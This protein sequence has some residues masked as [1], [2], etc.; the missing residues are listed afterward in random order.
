MNDIIEIQDLK[1]PPI[2][3]GV[4]E[5]A[6]A[7]LR[8]QYKE[9]DASTDEGYEHCKDGCREMTALRTAVETR[10]KD[11]K[12]PALD[13]GRQVD[14]LA[15][16]LIRDIKL[17]EGPV[18]A[19]KDRIDEIKQAEAR[20]AA[21][22]EQ[23]RIDGIKENI[24]KIEFTAREQNPLDTASDYQTHITWLN[25][26]AITEDVFGEF[27]DEAKT[28]RDAARF[29]L[30][31]WH[32][33]ALEREED[34]RKRAE[35]KAKLDKQRKEQEAT[36]KRQRE[37]G[38]ALE[39]EKLDAEERKAAEEKAATEKAERE[40]Q[41]KAIIE[42][43]RITN[44]KEAIDI[45]ATIPDR[46]TNMSAFALDGLIDAEQD[47]KPDELIFQEFTA[48]AIDAWQQSLDRLAVMAK[49]TRALEEQERRDEEARL[50][51]KAK[52]V[53]WCDAIATIPE[54]E[55]LNDDA[56]KII[57]KFAPELEKFYGRLSAAIGKL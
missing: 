55:V 36:E 33:L 47:S 3:Y 56:Q 38:E 37:A 31:Q 29:K 40:A 11:L 22:A 20:K 43:N 13:W 27:V 50:P 16:D 10:R 2:E 42:T 49:E 23:A 48:E 5:A 53:R 18:R 51:D 39:K 52:L 35:E 45:K 14:K 12:A 6:L 25:E 24:A 32:S 44:I 46:A 4:T 21:E 15:K 28:A 41:Q 34:D 7:E 57:K 26:L 19:E 1:F 17:I 8:E 54:P 30:T 9:P